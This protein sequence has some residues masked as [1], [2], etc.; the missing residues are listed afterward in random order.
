[1]E[2]YTEFIKTGDKAQ[3]DSWLAQVDA[4][5]AAGATKISDIFYDSLI[6][7]YEIRFGPRLVV[8]TK[9]TK[10][11]VPLPI[12]MMSLNK[13]MKD[14]ELQSFINKNPG[15][16]VVMDKI[17]GASG[18]YEI[19]GGKQSFYNRGDGTVGSDL[20]YMIPYLKLPLLPFDVHVKGELVIYKADYLPFQEEYKTNLAMSNGLI[21]SQSA[22]PAKLALF[23]FIA[24]DISFPSNQNIELKMSQS[25]EYL[26]KY[27]FLIPYAIVSA[28]LS[29]EGLSKVFA[30]RRND[31]P[32]EVDGMVIVTDKPIKYEERLIR[33]NPKYAVAFKEYTDVADAVVNHVEW[34]ASKHRQIKPVVKI[35][36]VNI[37]RK[38]I[39]SATGFN[40]KWIVENKVGPGTKLI[41]AD[42][43]IPYI[44]TVIEGTQP[45]MPP[46][47]VYPPG[48]W[49]WNETGV[50]IVLLEDNDEVKIARIYEFFS[51]IGAKY[52]G[53]TTLAKFYRAGFN[54]VKKMIETP[55]ETFL[56]AGIEGVGQGIV[57]RVV[58]SI[59]DTLPQ[60]SIAQI[61]AG[62]NEFGH[63]FGERKLNAILR[64]YPNILD[65]NPT[66]EQISDIDGFADKTAERFVEGL[67]K[68]RAFLNDIPL[69]NQIVRRQMV[70][71]P[72]V[73]LPAAGL[74]MVT[75]PPILS[76]LPAL[77]PPVLSPLPVLAPV[78]PPVLSPLS[79]LTGVAPILSPLPAVTPVKAPVVVTQPPVYQVQQ[80]AVYQTPVIQQQPRLQIQPVPV[81]QVVQQPVQRQPAA[82][83]S[84]AGISVVFTGFRDK[85]LENII[86]ARGGSVKT[87]VSKKTDYVIVGGK[88]G[89]GAAKETKAIELGVPVVNIAEFK[90]MFGL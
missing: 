38:T 36:P 28:T 7:I 8:G 29:T 14:K 5:Y 25:I 79:V 24:Y 39:K 3:I 72:L 76:P 58:N 90:A 13:I 70:G 30:Q 85:Q 64:T 1:M 19:I 11:E 63:G 65:M 62:S 51:K 42:N 16:Y 48:S 75:P 6:R 50:D 60:A 61:M 52:V 87:S 23:H 84:L 68:F 89:E 66:V 32:Y 40:A 15:P 45:Q 53:E 26:A 47:N 17:N 21:N 10:N 2:E 4:A 73:G 71:S 20:T 86:N 34:E 44:M 37:N 77:V 69:L 31:A 81:Y 18:L 56:A 22:D 82:G 55:A 54:S 74:P 27:G 49:Q 33:E 46:E 78:A 41:I 80:P 35:E 43:T 12:A 88:K 67:P 59:R 9:A 57:T 83:A